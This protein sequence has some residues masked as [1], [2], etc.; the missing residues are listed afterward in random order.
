MRQLLSG[1]QAPDT[2]LSVTTSGDVALPSAPPP[3]PVASTSRC[4]APDTVNRTHAQTEGASC[5]ANNLRPLI[6]HLDPLAGNIHDTNQ[7]SYALLEWLRYELQRESGVEIS[8]ATALSAVDVVRVRQKPFF[9]VLVLYGECLSTRALDGS[10]YLHKEMC[11][12]FTLDSSISS[13]CYSLW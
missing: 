8:F 2:A 4:E 12:N 13:G 3:F 11:E 5:D 10:I 6:L 9:R 1:K 7:I